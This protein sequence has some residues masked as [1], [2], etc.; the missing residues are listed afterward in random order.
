MVDP[1]LSEPGEG[2]GRIPGVCV[3][4]LLCIPYIYELL[5][6]MSKNHNVNIV[7]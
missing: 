1:R 3:D 5:L 6:E 4:A 7:F 2:D